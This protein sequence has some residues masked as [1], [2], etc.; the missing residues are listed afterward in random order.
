MICRSCGQM[1]P[2]DSAFCEF[3]GA[4]V[5][6]D[7]PEPA[8]RSPVKPNPLRKLILPVLAVGAAVVILVTYNKKKNPDTPSKPA[9]SEQEG[10][11]EVRP[12]FSLE[13]TE[14]ADGMTAGDPFKEQ[15]TVNQT[16]PDLPVETMTM[17]T[18][19]TVVEPTVPETTAMSEPAAP[20]AA[21]TLSTTEPANAMDIEWY[22][23]YMLQGGNGAGQVI[24]NP[25][26]SRR[27]TGQ[28]LALVNGGWKA[29]MC[30]I[31][32]DIYIPDGERYFNVALAASGSELSLTANWKY[33]FDATSG[34]NVEESGSDVFPG[35]WDAET[36]SAVFQSNHGRIEIFDFYY[37]EANQRQ[38]AVGVYLWPSGE[39]TNLALMR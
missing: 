39:V 13:E 28:E 15:A 9:A 31:E 32:N 6:A 3:C 34:H 30:F 33:V 5:E 36:G 24:T 10:Q 38:Y 18:E 25:A 29:Y 21:E 12:F 20:D 23:D 27:I 14:E 1:L 37:D 22:M 11:K 35:T 19:P 17:Q 26:Y 2:D 7:F 16:L 4:K 8:P